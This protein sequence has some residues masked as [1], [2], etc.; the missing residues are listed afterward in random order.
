MPTDTPHE[1]GMVVEA[2]FL[3]GLIKLGRGANE[4]ERDYHDRLDATLSPFATFSAS[5]VDFDPTA[6]PKF[7]LNQIKP[8]L[9]QAEFPRVALVA[10]G[11][12]PLIR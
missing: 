4:S 10:I 8:G 6:V 5:E 9:W 11:T 12:K 2:A 1:P 3:G 7:T